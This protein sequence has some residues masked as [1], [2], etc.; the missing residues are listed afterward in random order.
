MFTVPESVRWLLKKDRQEEA[1]KSLAWVRASEDEDVAAEF[2]EIQA[3]LAAEREL[4]ATAG[5][6]EI[7]SKGNRRRLLTGCLAFFFQIATG[8]TALAYFSPQF[9]KL[10][11]PATVPDAEGTVLL[12]TGLFGAI[13][14]IACSFFVVFFANKLGRK[15]PLIYGGSVMAVCM[16]I[17][18]IVLRTADFTAHGSVPPAGRAT[19]AMIFLAIMA[20]NFSWGP[21]PWTLVPE[22]FPNRIREIGVALCMV[23]LHFWQF[24]FTL[25]TPYMIAGT[26]VRGWGTFLFYAIFDVIMVLW[27]IFFMP[28]TQDKSLERVNAELD[29]DEELLNKKIDAERA[30]SVSAKHDHT[31]RAESDSAPEVVATTDGKS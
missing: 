14:L 19:V 2:A 16:L 9:F 23:L 27:V 26:G 15:K 7:V 24:I 30:D 22:I 29:H 21:V 5:R 10:I 6:F 8:A 3:G 12:L 4:R 31:E 13:K 20:Y 17:T 11:V 25:V 28:E 1:W 18:A